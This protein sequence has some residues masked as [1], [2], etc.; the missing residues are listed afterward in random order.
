MKKTVLTFGL[1]SGAILS[2]MMLATLPFLDRIGFDRGEIIG[3]TSMVVAFLLIFFGVRSYRDNVAGGTIGFGRAFAVAAL[4]SVV[5]SLCYVATWEV[6]YWKLTPDFGTKYQAHIL[7]KARKNGESEDA[8][9]RKKTELD[10]FLKLYENPAINVAI[11][12]LEPLPV[13][14]V[15]SLVSAG[16]LRRRRTPSSGQPG[17]VSRSQVSM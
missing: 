5:A 16:V 10:G 1:I 13:A 12:F 9:A 2:T 7:D 11:T 17:V 8:I 15:V 4:I 3:Y 6:I 14:M